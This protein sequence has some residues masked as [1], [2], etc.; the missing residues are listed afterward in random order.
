[1]RRLGQ[2]AQ[3]GGQR[4]LDDRARPLPV[5]HQ[6]EGRLDGIAQRAADRGRPNPATHRAHHG[7]HR[8][9]ATV[10]HGD[11]LDLVIGANAGPPPRHGLGG[12]RSGQRALELVRSHQDAHPANV[13]SAPTHHETD[14]DV[15][16]GRNDR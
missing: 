10:G 11:D 9:L 13:Q 3:A 4:H 5:T 8:A 16:R 2:Q 7:V 14:R 12:L 1:M 6:P 15:S